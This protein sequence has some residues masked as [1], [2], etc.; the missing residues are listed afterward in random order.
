MSIFDTSDYGYEDLMRERGYSNLNDL[1]NED[2][3][4]ECEEEDAYGES[5]ISTI[6]KGYER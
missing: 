6:L 3:E 5:L 4:R 1:R 2:Y